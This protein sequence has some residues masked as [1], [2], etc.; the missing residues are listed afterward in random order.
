MDKFDIR[1]ITISNNSDNDIIYSLSKTD[2]VL[3]IEASK[4]L[5]YR[6]DGKDVLK[7]DVSHSFID[8]LSINKTDIIDRRRCD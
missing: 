1:D 8:S 6:L 3:D 5:K 4:I 2:T 7:V